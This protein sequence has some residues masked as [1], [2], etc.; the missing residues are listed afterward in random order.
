MGL[1]LCHLRDA[2]AL[3]PAPTFL[4]LIIV[5]TL[6]P[7][8]RRV[9]LWQLYVI[10]TDKSKQLW[11]WSSWF[12]MINHRNWLMLDII[13]SCL[14]VSHCFCLLLSVPPGFICLTTLQK[15]TQ[16][17][18]L[19]L[20][21]IVMRRLCGTWNRMKKESYLITV[22]LCAQPWSQLGCGPQHWLGQL[23][24]F[25]ASESSCGAMWGIA[26]LGHS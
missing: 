18:I 26:V 1:P 23:L 20:F 15:D 17:L 7:T 14:S 22:V 25:P 8:S 13:S 12:E 11:G 16:S 2:K 19:S 6:Q 3:S 21:Y 10:S 24:L 9:L 5:K 4:S